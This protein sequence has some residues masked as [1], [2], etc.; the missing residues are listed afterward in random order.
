MTRSRRRMGDRRM[1]SPDPGCP[2]CG[3]RGFTFHDDGGQGSAKLCRCRFRERDER[4]QRARTAVDQLEELADRLE[5]ELAED[6]D[7]GPTP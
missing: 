6:D 7:G 4:E 1:I 5:R 2:D 3:G